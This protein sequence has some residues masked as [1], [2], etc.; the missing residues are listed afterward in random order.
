MEDGSSNRKF[1]NGLLERLPGKMIVMQVLP[2]CEEW[3]F[4]PREIGDEEVLNPESGVDPVACLKKHG[5]CVA[6][7]RPPS[8]VNAF[9]KAG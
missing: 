9:S 5:S 4:M 7:C 6:A 2:D 8:D 3:F 1:I